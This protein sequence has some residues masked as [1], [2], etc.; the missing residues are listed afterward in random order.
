MIRETQARGMQQHRPHRQRHAQ[1]HRPAIRE[2]DTQIANRVYHETSGLR[3]TTLHGPG[4]PDDL[5]DARRRLAAVIVNGKADG[6]PAIT[7]ANQLSGQEQ[8]AIHH[9][10]PAQAA[11]EDSLDAARAGLANGPQPSAGTNFYLDY[12]QRTPPWAAGKTP[13]AVYGPFLN[14]AGG[15]DVPRGSR[16]R[17]K[18][19]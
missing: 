13:R 1:S 3:P 10:P 17:I 15:G 16:V 9:Y 2:S 12:G 8:Q 4:S 6:N 14:A 19:Y 5:S 18:V 11:H 7:G